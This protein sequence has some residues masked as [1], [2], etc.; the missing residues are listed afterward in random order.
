[1]ITASLLKARFTV[2]KPLSDGARFDLAIERDGTFKRIQ[3]K[4]GRLKNGTI[5]FRLNSVTAGGRRRR[6]YKG[7]AD[8]FGVYCPENGKSYLLPVDALGDHQATIR[9]APAKNNQ[10]TRPAADFEIQAEEANLVKAPG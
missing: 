7:D 10:A 6:N 8:L 5:R 2:L 9:I 4:T 3:C 1:M